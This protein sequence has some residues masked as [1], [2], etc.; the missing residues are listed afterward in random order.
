[1]KRFHVYVEFIDGLKITFKTKSDVRKE[2][3]QQTIDGESCI[4]TDDDIVLNL[5]KIKNM[6][7]KR[8]RF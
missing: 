1:M 3:F 5:A 2:M 8:L 7:V 4:V 6:K